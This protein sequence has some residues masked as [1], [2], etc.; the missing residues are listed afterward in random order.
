MVAL[1]QIQRL[2]PL[3]QTA[4]LARFAVAPIARHAWALATMLLRVVCTKHDDMCN[5]Q[6]NIWQGSE[7]E[8]GGLRRWI[9]S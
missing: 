8:A 1:G 7:S 5:G 9:C 3:S 6:K 2:A 4:S